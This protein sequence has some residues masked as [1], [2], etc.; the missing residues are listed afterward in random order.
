M[1][2]RTLVTVASRAPGRPE[3]MPPASL[4]GIAAAL[5]VAL[6]TAWSRR[7]VS[8]DGAI[9]LRIINQIKAGNGPVFNPGER[10][11]AAT[12][13]LWL[14]LLTLADAVTPFRLEWITV[15]L[16]IALA[17][18]GLGLAAIGATAVW[19]RHT[20]SGH[21]LPL[22]IGVF[23][24]LPP[25]WDYASSAM[26]GGMIL[27]WLGA[28]FWVMVVAATTPSTDWGRAAIG[29]AA[30][31]GLG[32]LIRPDLGLYTT[33]LLAGLLVWAGARR[34]RIVL[35]SVAIALPLTY[36]VFRMGYYGLLVP[37]TA[38]AKE[39]SHTWWG[40]GWNY[41]Y[42]FVGETGLAVPLVAAFAVLGLLWARL[43]KSEERRLAAALLLFVG[44]GVLHTV[45]IVRVGGD[46]MFGRMLLPPLFA[47]LAPIAIVP[48]RGVFRA[49][50][51]LALAWA[52]VVTARSS[53][54]YDTPRVADVR[55]HQNRSGEVTVEESTWSGTA[56]WGRR[57]ATIDRAGRPRWIVYPSP[58]HKPIVELDVAL[59]KRPTVGTISGIGW[60]SYA[61]DVDTYIDDTLG[62][63]NPLGSHV[64]LHQRQTPGHEKQL[65]LAWSAARFVAPDVT[66]DP[67][68]R[69]EVANARAALACGEI[70]RI[71]DA[72]RERLTFGRFVGN[73]LAAPALT[74]ARFEADPAL[75]RADQC[76]GKG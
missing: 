53:P 41:L 26:E 44:A 13:T 70:K 22:G 67:I 18:A 14:G 21:V 34:F 62:L 73:V 6:A 76:G 65:P 19:R 15:V 8:D 29:W 16:G 30:L 51:A 27:A 9:N 11:E 37:N 57:L 31:L 49:A 1:P 38:L 55:L 46:W 39:A 20:K 33:C 64:R 43:W 58:Y 74:R 36:E 42:G 60:A 68:S 25:A 5:A 48:S 10:V 75:A 3:S 54:Y 72:T 40:Q 71:L 45:Y 47:V 66:V 63:S 59:A 61:A 12:S 50:T 52:V 24:L 56:D 7:W 4:L 35:F 2:R 23:A 32:P 69:S 28:C 17:V